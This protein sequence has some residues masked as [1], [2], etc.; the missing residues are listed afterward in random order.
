[1]KKLLVL[2]AILAFVPLAFGDQ[3]TL[4]TYDV[5]ALSADPGLV[6]N[7]QKV[8]DTPTFWLNPGQS[9]TFDLFKIWTSESTV[10]P[11]DTIPK[12]IEVDF[13][14]NPPDSSGEVNGNTYGVATLFGLIQYG[15][16]VWSGP[17]VVNPVSGGQYV[18]ALSNETF[19]IGVFGLDSGIHDGATVTATLTYTQAAPAQTPEP[20][21]MLLL[22]SGLAGLA[23]IIRRRRS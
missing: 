6:L 10:N 21:S 7:T 9:T 20:A 23:G 19:N 13:A 17:A 14:F 12:S 4:Q 22:G 5:N 18:L 16:V 8:A 15:K 2:I 3:F 11:D 1:M